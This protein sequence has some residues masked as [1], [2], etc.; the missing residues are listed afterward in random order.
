MGVCV[1]QFLKKLDEIGENQ[2]FVDITQK[3]RLA[4]SHRLFN[5]IFLVIL[6]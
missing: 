1:Y 2:I 4:S 5:S 6:L 3:G